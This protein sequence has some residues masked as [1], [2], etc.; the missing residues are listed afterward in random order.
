M[1]GYS[2]LLRLES[3]IPLVLYKCR[4]YKIERHPSSFSLSQILDSS[5]TQNQD[6]LT[7]LRQTTVEIL[8][9]QRYLFHVQE[10]TNL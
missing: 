8:H 10:I 3:E 6:Y 2:K 4:S 9:R 7:Y 1:Y 5:N